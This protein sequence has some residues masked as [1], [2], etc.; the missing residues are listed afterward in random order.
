MIR[1][2]ERVLNIDSGLIHKTYKF[3]YQNSHATW[4]DQTKKVENEVF[5]HA[6]QKRHY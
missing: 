5:N 6:G 4:D 2:V 3:G 1:M